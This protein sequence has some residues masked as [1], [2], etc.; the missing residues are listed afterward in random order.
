MNLKPMN[1][2]NFLSFQGTKSNDVA[3]IQERYI[4]C[5]RTFLEATCPSQPN[6]LNELLRTLPE[7][8]LKLSLIILVSS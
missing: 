8:R 3:I 7:V 5:L 1:V 4:K 6:R 2:F